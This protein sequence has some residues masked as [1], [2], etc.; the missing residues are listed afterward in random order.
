MIKIDQWQFV[1]YQFYLAKLPCSA[2][3]WLPLGC[4]GSSIANLSPLICYRLSIL[5]SPHWEL[6]AQGP[7]TY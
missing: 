1:V 7:A 5:A 6:V 3:S 2:A 4:D